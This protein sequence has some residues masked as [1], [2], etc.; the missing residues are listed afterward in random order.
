MKAKT[1]KKNTLVWIAFSLGCF[2]S[3][4]YVLIALGLIPIGL[5]DPSKEGGIIIF[6][7][8]GCYLLGGSLILT[9][10]KWLWVIGIL[11][12]ALVMLFFFNMY[13]ARP[14]VMFSAGGLMTKIPQLL[15]E[16]SLIMLL[17]KNQVSKK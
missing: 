13:Q 16:I 17:V 5:T 3:I 4:A 7:A 10:R 1:N 14:E 2:I 8:A 6:I 11:I 12:N 9:Q 15:L